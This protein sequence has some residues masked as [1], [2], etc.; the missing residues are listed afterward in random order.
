M[1]TKKSL[2]LSGKLLAL[3]F[4]LLFI[5]FALYKLF[6]EPLEKYHSFGW[7]L[8][9]VIT[10]SCGLSFISFFCLLF[11]EMK[12][13]KKESKEPTMTK[14]EKTF[15]I[16]N[17]I[18][19]GS[20]F[21]SVILFIIIFAFSAFFEVDPFKDSFNISSWEKLT[22][23]ILLGLMGLSML[24]AFIAPVIRYYWFRKKK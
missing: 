2:S 21:S 16:W 23:L 6:G 20:I 1:E 13:S 19:T 24:L 17:A 11:S 14:R 18:A 15:K 8:F 22:V 9:L 10:I 12:S 3:S 7:Y 5:D 4:I